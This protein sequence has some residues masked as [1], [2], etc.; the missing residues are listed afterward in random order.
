MQSGEIISEFSCLDVHNLAGATIHTGI[1]N[2]KIAKDTIK[3]IKVNMPLLAKI[4]AVYYANDKWGKFNNKLNESN[5]KFTKSKGLGKTLIN[6]EIKD[7]I[8]VIIFFK[9]GE[10]Y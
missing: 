5:K 9:T 6:K 1:K 8:K 10:F 7:I 3:G 4:A 2:K